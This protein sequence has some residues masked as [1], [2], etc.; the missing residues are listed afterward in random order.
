VSGLLPANAFENNDNFL[1]YPNAPTLSNGGISYV[2]G[3]SDFNFYF[4][5]FGF[6]CGTMSYKESTGGNCASTDQVV[7]LRILPVY[8]PA[9]VPE[10][11]SIALLAAAFGGLAFA[12]RRRSS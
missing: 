11:A 1:Y 8:L 4:D 10:P 6:P 9:T 3:G 2:A 5:N 12:R 7:S